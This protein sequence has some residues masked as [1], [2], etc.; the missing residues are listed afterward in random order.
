MWN[1]E[2]FEACNKILKQN[3]ILIKP[4]DRYIIWIYNWFSRCRRF[5]GI[6]YQN[7][8]YNFKLS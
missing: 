1:V 8:K 5:F 6:N 4:Y 2:L 7:R 3:G